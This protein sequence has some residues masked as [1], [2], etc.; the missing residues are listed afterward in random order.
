MAYQTAY[1]KANFPAEYMAGVMS[2]NLN[3][4]AKLSEM[5]DECKAMGIPVKGPDINESV[6]KFGVT[7][8]GEIRFGLAAVKSMSANAVTSII[9]ERDE[10][11]SHRINGFFRNI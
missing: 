9:K 4:L 5:M 8:K 6:E 11:S 7:S 1:L 3:N 2:R 10:Q